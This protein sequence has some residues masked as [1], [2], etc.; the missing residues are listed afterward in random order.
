[1]F[2]FQR[3]SEENIIIGIQ[4]KN[5]HQQK[6][7]TINNKLPPTT[8]SYHHQQKTTTTTKT[9]RFFFLTFYFQISL[10]TFCHWCGSVP[11]CTRS[12]F[13]LEISGNCFWA[14]S[15]LEQSSSGELLKGISIA[16]IH[17]DVVSFCESLGFLP[18]EMGLTGRLSLLQENLS[19]ILWDAGT[20]KMRAK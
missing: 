10:K 11:L 6:T 2:H 1:M 9:G 4:L 20:P 8:K 18:E 19:S 13:L 14:V 16:Q 15:S 7:T 3:R 5:H 17:L 12:M